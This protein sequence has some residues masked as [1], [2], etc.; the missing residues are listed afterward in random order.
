MGAG[1]QQVCGNW[2]EP[3]PATLRLRRR[4]ETSPIQ[5]PLPARQ[6]PFFSI[7]PRD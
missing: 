7:R 4:D 6:P 1:A 2:S 3:I 5:P